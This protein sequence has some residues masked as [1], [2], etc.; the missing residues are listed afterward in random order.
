M[1]KIICFLLGHNWGEFSWRNYFGSDKKFD[2]KAK[3]NRCGEEIMGLEAESL[4][5]Q[6]KR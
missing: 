5:N 1:K 3:C 2:I 4:L 6:Y